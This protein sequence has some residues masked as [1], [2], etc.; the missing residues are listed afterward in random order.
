[1][2]NVVSMPGV[3]LDVRSGEPRPDISQML[4]DLAARADAGEIDALVIG[5]SIVDGG[6]LLGVSTPENCYYTM[7]GVCEALKDSVRERPADRIGT[8]DTDYDGP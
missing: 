5:A 1:M 7:L 3:R 4:R 6:C 2:D 8:R